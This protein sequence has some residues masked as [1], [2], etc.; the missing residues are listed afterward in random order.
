MPKRFI[1]LS[2]FAAIIWAGDNPLMN[3]E[4]ANET[5][6]ETYKVELMTTKGPVILEINRSWSPL[7]ADRFYNLVKVGYYDNVA[8]FRMVD[9][10]VAQFGIHGDPAVTAAWKKAK[11]KDDPGSKSNKRGFVSFATSGPHTRTTQLFINFGN[12]SNLDSMGFTPFAQVVEGMDV[13]DSLYSGYQQKPNQGMITKEGNAYLKSK[14]P[15]LDYITTA[16]IKE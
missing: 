5:A 2:F 11:I 12:N 3:P 8:F 9:G 13:V 6:P 1:L 15:S 7:G 14:F 4:A 10:F 16:T